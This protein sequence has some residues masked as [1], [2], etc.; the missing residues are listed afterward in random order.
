MSY[1]KYNEK[2]EIIANS[3]KKNKVLI[4]ISHREHT[5]K[6]CD[7]VISLKDGNITFAGKTEDYF[8]Q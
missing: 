3:I 7:E 5:I 8:S 4:L 1:D 2:V 6:N